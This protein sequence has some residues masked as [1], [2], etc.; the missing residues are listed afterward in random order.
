MPISTLVTSM[1]DEA[2]YIIEWVAYHRAIGF[3]RLVVLANDCTDGTHEMLLRLHEM[4]AIAY[5]ENKV[6]VGQK[7]HSRALKIANLTPEV[8]SADFVM[9]LD[10][11]EFLVVK[12]P[13]HTL[14]VLVEAMQDR[15]ADMMVI[16]W[17]IFGSSHNTEFQDRPVIERFTQSMDA[18]DLPK[19]GVKTLFR[20]GDKLR[21]AIHFPKN[22]MKRGEPVAATAGQV[23]IDAGGQPLAREGLTWNGGRQTIHR[24]LAEVAHF[25]IKSLDEYLLKIFRGDG[26]MNSNRHGIDYWRGA[27]KNQVSDLV[28]ADNVQGFRQEYERLFA[29]PVL[30]GLHHGSVTARVDRLSKIL[31]K[32][33]VQQLRA[34]LEKSTAGQMDA[35][36]VQQSRDLVTQMSPVVR[37]DTLIEGD[38]PHST[39]LSL[40]DA[41]LA[42]AAGIL[43]R[44]SKQTRKNGVMF[45][46]EQKFGRR[47]ITNLVEGLKRAQKNDRTACLGVRW[48]H[49]QR[50]ALP[51]DSWPL[52]D[53]ILVVLTRDDANLLAGYP[54]HV[55]QSKARHL[56]R[57]QRGLPSP[58]EVLTGAETAAEVAALIRAGQL[59]NPRLRIRRYLQDHPQ[60]VVLNLDRP[61][62]VASA[63][64]DIEGRGP[65]GP[66]AA[67]LLRG[68]LALDVPDDQKARKKGKRQK[69]KPAAESPA[70][71]P[72]GGRGDAGEPL[73]D[74]GVRSLQIGILTLPM[75]RN[76]GG[77]LQ[78]FALMQTLRNLGHRP[79]LLNRRHGAKEPSAAPEAEAALYS[80]RIGLGKNVQNRLFVER[81]VTPIS[82]EFP[83]SAALAAQVDRYDLDAVIVGSDQVWRPKYARGI[84]PDFFLEFLNGS[85]R[86]TRRISYAASFGSDRDEYGP[87]DKALAASLLK[88][89]DAVS[90]REDSAVTLCRDMFGVEAEHVLDP[91]LLLSQDDYAALLS[92]KQRQ[93]PGG[94]LL[95]YVL[96][97]TP[98]K[99]EVVS[100]LAAALGVEPRTASGQ[101]F[102][103]A[104]PLKA[105]GGD[106]TVERWLGSFRNAAFVVTDSFHGVAFSIIFNK[107]FLAYGNAERGLARF[108]SLLGAVGLQHRI[109]TGAEEVDLQRLLA[110]VDW[111]G[112]N[113]RVKAL[114]TRSLR[115]LTK[116]L[117]GVHD[118]HGT[119]G[120]AEAGCEVKKAPAPASAT[121]DLAARKAAPGA[122]SHPLNVHCT[123]CGLCVS[124]AQGALKMVWTTD[125]FLEPRAVSGPVPA[126][127]VRVCPFNAAPEKAVEDEDALA[128]TFLRD[129][130]KSDPRLGRFL[131]TY[132]GY[133][134]GFRPTSSSGGI[135]TY[136]FDQLLRQGHAD[137]LFVVRKAGDGEYAYQL[138]GRDDEI[139]TTSKTRYFPVSLD[140]LFS[141]IEAVQGRVAISGVACFIKAIRLKQHYHPQLRDKI[142]FLSGIICGGLKSRFYTDFLAKSAG[143]EGV[144][145]DP[146]YRVKSPERLSSDYSFAA[147]E[148][149]DG[150]EHRVRMQK[151]GDMWGTG[152]FKSRAC[153]FC[154]DVM[155]ELADI[156]LGDAWL[157]E[158]KQDGM[159]NSVIV[160]RTP[161][162]DQ[163]I[164]EGIASGALAAKEVSA[165]IAARTQSGGFNHKQKAVRFRLLMEEEYGNRV[166][167]FVRPR[168]L[169]DSSVAEIFVQILRERTRAKS[170][171][172]W[173]QTRD[174]K[175][176]SR[177]MRS[178][179][180]LLSAVTTARKQSALVQAAATEA[181]QAWPHPRPIDPQVAA[182]GPLVRW[183]EINLRNGRIDTVLLQAFVPGFAVAADHGAGAGKL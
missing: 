41:G 13:P 88:D 27:D 99:Q 144:Y 21:L 160:T 105:K 143:I 80:D 118:R 155:T 36:D 156:S 153:D 131:G 31:A 15:S 83:S 81:H 61:D 124:E 28:V 24:D 48:F 89:F 85:T 104:D 167:P 113:R 150:Q 175:A 136:V 125:G 163:I 52:D 112:V 50:R 123:G 108:Q 129:T 30:A 32:P 102:A 110:P 126:H 70:T 4:G 158:Y 139:E 5:Y 94:H 93:A 172:V 35:Q 132:V 53:E 66:L 121:L 33:D 146:E 67:D 171:S 57:P 47:P 19:V 68:A 120:A 62:E 166:I 179:L 142:P 63:L 180:R 173:R 29:D 103:S 44:M 42:D 49:N 127:A 10:A 130:G 7:P 3:D 8:K 6:P 138:F 1:K 100:R 91:T 119:V 183:I 145:R 9:V 151:L 56:L 133:S 76:Y 170:L 87:T 77:N 58:G 39:L 116:A 135:A 79:V 181:L 37:T 55:A 149:A 34:I 169:A 92:E 45:W 115:F 152:L 177:R 59:E 72:Q 18:L 137:W 64:R 111:R 11:D 178:T 25:M 134:T 51:E 73:A 16:P 23:W 90:V 106:Q 107:P 38:I 128:G 176:F 84:L 182:I 20:T 17:R 101:P 60:A 97:A 12:K 22:V 168:T 40:T 26:L 69:T 161:L 114:R 141:A 82:R 165:D 164:R 157:P 78:A 43:W 86:P 117:A 159:G 122:D 147:T 74:R 148:I 162:A 2:P 46:P 71:P 174:H 75:N 65:S 140:Q 14:D 95:T 96:D 154:T 109:V 54:A 98:D